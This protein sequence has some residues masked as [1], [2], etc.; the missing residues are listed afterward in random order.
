[1][2]TDRDRNNQDIEREG[3][4]R[5]TDEEPIGR[6]EEGEDEFEDSDEADEDDDEMDEGSSEEA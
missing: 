3:T 2:A 6:A 1:M 5:A 4:G